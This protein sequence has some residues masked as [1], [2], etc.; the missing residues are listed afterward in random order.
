MAWICLTCS[1]VAGIR[2]F[3]YRINVLTAANLEF[4]VVALLPRCCSMWDRN[5]SSMV[6][7]MCSRHSWDGCL[8]SR[9]L[10][11]AN[12]SRKAWAYVS[13]VWGLSPV[14]RHVLPEKGSD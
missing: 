9:S 2:D 13:Q 11:N 1:N 10:A 3:T 14:Y 5:S 12:N 8:F 6:A 4:R 7:S